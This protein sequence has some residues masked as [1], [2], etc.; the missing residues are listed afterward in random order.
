[1]VDEDS[2]VNDERD[3]DATTPMNAEAHDPLREGDT[4]AGEVG[5]GT[6]TATRDRRRLIGVVSLVVIV[7]TVGVVIGL[8]SSNNADAAIIDAV[9]SAIGSKT[10]LVGISENV[11]SAGGS[12]SVTGT[13]AFDFTDRAFQM[14][15]GGDVGGNHVA[16]SAIY[17]GGTIFEQVPGVSKIAP[18]KIWISMDLSSLT[19]QSPS[20]TTSALGGDPL[21]SLYEL[22]QQ[23]A[24]VVDLGSSSVDGQSAEG[25]RVTFSPAFLQQ[26][27]H[28]ANFPS[29]MQAAATSTKF[30][31]GSETVYLAHDTL[32]R[33]TL[34][35]A[36][37]SSTSG[38]VTFEEDL[39]F[40]NFGTPVSVVAPPSSQVV[41]IEQFL[42]L[43][44]SATSF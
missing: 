43:A 32:I 15:V 6:R 22:T 25:Y 4:S 26:Q 34:N 27:V 1:M 12:L 44:H 18:G 23:G 37:Q 5:V 33:L 7:A 17:L 39:N 31:S 29:W 35:V 24:T 9:N 28:N 11:S 41:T 42:Q 10:A 38:P 21:T 8:G 2:N 16:I 13:G 19:A 30:H 36:V 40:N 3:L 14:D 20:S